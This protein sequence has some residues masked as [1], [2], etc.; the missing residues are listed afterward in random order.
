MNVDN[1]SDTNVFF[2]IY[3]FSS[4]DIIGLKEPQYPTHNL[5]LP[6]N[7]TKKGHFPWGIGKVVFLEILGNPNPTQ[8]S[9]IS[10][11]N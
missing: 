3:S 6:N 7:K 9:I 11:I 4:S 1:M 5:N 2:Q 8:I 10:I